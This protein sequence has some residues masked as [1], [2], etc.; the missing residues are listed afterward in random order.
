MFRLILLNVV[1]DEPLFRLVTIDDE[2]DEDEDVG[3]EDEEDEDEL[4]EED[5][6]LDGEDEDY[7]K[8]S[9]YWWSR[10]LLSS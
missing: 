9:N 1:V 4:E 10:P 5:D 8:H 3:E 6:E 7:S 2:E